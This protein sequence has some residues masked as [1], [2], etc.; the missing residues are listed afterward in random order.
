MRN[1]LLIL[2]LLG[3]FG[4]RQK[5]EQPI[6]NVLLVPMQVHV[7][8]YQNEKENIVDSIFND[9]VQE[10][11]ALIGIYQIKKNMAK[12]KVTFS[13]DSVTIKD[14]WIDTKYL[15]I[16]L[17]HYSDTVKIMLHPCLDSKISFEIKNPQWEEFYIVKDA[18]KNWLYIQSIDSSQNY[19]WL[20][21]E[22]QCD[23]PYTSCN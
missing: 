10:N 15:G 21:P 11:Y 23:N 9:T 8:L 13:M 19:G 3:L 1:L 16:H 14:G 4:C 2:F 18:C 6:G 20:A 5:K 7:P 17:A 22:Y 12:V